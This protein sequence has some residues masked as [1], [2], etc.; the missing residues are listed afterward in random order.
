MSSGGKEKFA[1]VV[2]GEYIR[3]LR[4]SLGLTQLQFAELMEVGNVTVANWEKSGLDGTRSSSFPNYKYLTTL[5]KQAMHHP[6]FIPAQKL[7]KYLKLASDHE[8]MPYYL[9]YLKE[10]ETDYLGVINSGSLVSVLF[11][12]LFDKDLERRGLPSPM[13]EIGN[14]IEQ[15]L[16][17]SGEEDGT[18]LEELAKESGSSLSSEGKKAANPPKAR[19]KNKVK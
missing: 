3:K 6:E 16:G 4:L 8:L 7:I 1:P 9:P 17:G 5:L 15:F 19:S 11:A 18:L 12:L 10:M 14:G 13:D 2:S